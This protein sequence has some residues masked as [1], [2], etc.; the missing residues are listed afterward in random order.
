MAIASGISSPI[1]GF[2][3]QPVMARGYVMKLIPRIT[4][5]P[6]SRRWC[7]AQVL[8]SSTAWPD[9]WRSSSWSVPSWAAVT[10]RGP[11]TTPI[12]TVHA[13]GRT[14]T[15][16]AELQRSCD[17]A[18]D[19]RRCRLSGGSPYLTPMSAPL[20]PSLLLMFPSRRQRRATRRQKIAATLV[21]LAALSGFVLVL[22]AA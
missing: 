12:N 13:A 16:P 5:S 9:C 10:R 2:V 14:D 1:P 7:A 4:C 11:A 17:Q 20:P 22:A 18:T 3:R 21:V 15:C 19:P 6:T 8:L